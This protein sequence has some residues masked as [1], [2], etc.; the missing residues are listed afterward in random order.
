MT[1]FPQ[2]LRNLRVREKRPLGELS[3]APRIAAL[4]AA[5][6]ESGR[7]LLR[8]SGTEALLRLLVEGRDAAFIGS[9]ADA[10]AAE[11][12]GEIGE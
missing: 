8:Y 10:I 12:Q 4:E 3:A 5:L 2:V 9:E 11:I 1:K 7:V 6:G